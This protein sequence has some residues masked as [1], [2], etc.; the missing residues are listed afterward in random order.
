[1]WGSV[2]PGALAVMR[3]I[4]QEFDPRGVLNPGRFVGGL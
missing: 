3:R 1:M 4:K 2:A